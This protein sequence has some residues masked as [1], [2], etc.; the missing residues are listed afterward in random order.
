[1]HFEAH[2][3]SKVSESGQHIG[4]K[5]YVV[6]GF[7]VAKEVLHNQNRSLPPLLVP[8]RLLCFQTLHL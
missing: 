8:L 6:P 3:A 1:M 4:D 2:V 5:F 7:I